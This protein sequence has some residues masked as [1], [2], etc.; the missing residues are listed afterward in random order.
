MARRDR[1]RLPEGDDGRT[2]VNMNVEGMPWHAHRR[3][4]PAPTRSD[5]ELTPEQQRAYKW[6]A[7]KA[8]LAVALIFGAVFA[9]FIAF[10]DFV[11][12]R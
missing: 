3:E 9:A 11:W 7:I 6:A 1:S 2:I 5:F 8:A 4:T 12:F 10:C